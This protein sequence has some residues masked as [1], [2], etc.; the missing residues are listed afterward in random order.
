MLVPLLLTPSH[1]AQYM[2]YLQL[3]K[4]YPR[5]LGY[6]FLHYFFSFVGQ[7]F[8]ISLFV[9]GISE[10]RGWETETFSGIYSG[11]TLC[12]AFLLPVIGQ[13]IDRL[14]VRYVSTATAVMM[15]SGC[16][17]LAFT[18]HWVW[19]AV[20]VLAVRLGGQGVLTL[21]ASTTIGRF[22]TVARG[23]S[24]SLSILGISAAEIIMPPLAT[25]FILTNGYRQMWLVAAAMLA[26]IFIPLVWLLIRRYDLFQR[27][28][29]VAAAADET[30]QTSWTRG[31][32]LRDRR[33][34]LIVP[35]ILFMPFVFTG[36]V[37][38]QSDVALLRGYTPANMALGLSIYGF[39]RA[40]MLFTVGSLI[41]RYRAERLL[42]YVLLP[43]MAGLGVFIL[44]EASWAVPALFCLAAISG[45]GITVIAPALWA[46]RY[47]PRFLG[48]I[49]ST[50]T[51]LVVLSSAAAPILFTWGLGWGITP[52]LLVIIGYGLLCVL[53]A[54]LEVR[55]MPK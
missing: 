29:T 7:T 11:V 28:D 13:Q 30:D 49:K 18:Y 21:T 40:I 4:A 12:A 26:F 45:G 20:G 43:V 41:D 22:F 15:L 38:N 37:F 9:A 50:V 39:T 8:F 5:Y 44:I 54:W 34:Q 27:A 31:Q 51:L 32:V 14:R 19:L 23:K 1:R 6:G 17:I 46:E 24:L 35:T 55:T 10:D 16:L 25:A 52:C 47:G 2:N 48:S 53:L 3:L 42:L 33:F 36:I